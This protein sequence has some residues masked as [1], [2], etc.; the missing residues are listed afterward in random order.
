MKVQV[1]TEWTNPKEL[2]R[3]KARYK[4][5]AEGS[6]YNVKLIKEKGI[7]V[8]FSAWSIGGG[9]MMHI[10]EYETFE[11]FEKMTT[12]PEV[13]K[14]WAKWSYLVDNVRVRTMYSPQQIPPET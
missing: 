13:R 1:V 9:H 10:A 7:N 6:A 12:D 11:D 14:N 2:E 5:D 4:Q 3:N 8:R